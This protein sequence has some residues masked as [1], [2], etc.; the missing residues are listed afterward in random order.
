MGWTISSS[1][2]YYKLDSNYEAPAAE[3]PLQGAD[4]IIDEIMYHV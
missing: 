1:F 3:V 4:Y 2:H